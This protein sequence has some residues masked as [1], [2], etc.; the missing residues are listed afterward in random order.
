MKKT[1]CLFAALIMCLTICLPAFAVIAENEAEGIRV[2]VSKK[3]G[4]PVY[5]YSDKTDGKGNFS[6]AYIPTKKKIPENTKFTAD[7][8]TA[9]VTAE[10]GSRFIES[11][12]DGDWIYLALADVSLDLKPVT[13]PGDRAGR[14]RHLTVFDDDVKLYEGP[15]E[16]YRAVKSLPEG[17]EIEAVKY[18]FGGLSCWYYTTV[19]N[20]SGWIKFMNNPEDVDFVCDISY[21]EDI[22]SPTGKIVTLSSLRIYDE[23]DSVFDGEPLASVPAG[24][25]LTFSNY[26]LWEFEDGTSLFAL[27]DYKGTKGWAV[28]VDEDSDSDAMYQVEG[29]MMINEPD[30]VYEDKDLRPGDNAELTIEPHTIVSFD[31]RYNE[32]V[33]TDGEDWFRPYISWYR[34][35]IGGRHY[36]ISFGSDGLTHPAEYEAK[37]YRVSEDASLTLYN[38]ASKKSGKAGAIPAGGSFTLLF[39]DDQNDYAV[40]FYDSNKVWRYVEYDGSR[41]WTQFEWEDAEIIPASLPEITLS[42][43]ADMPPVTAEDEKEFSLNP[44]KDGKF[45]LPFNLFG[46]KDLGEELD[47]IGDAIDEAVDK[48]EKDPDSIK[49]TAAAARALA[50]KRARREVVKDLIIAGIAAAGI[51]LIKK[52]DEEAA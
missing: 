12:Y 31:Y 43:S 8:E 51:F 39:T 11:E 3:G 6:V 46:D 28:I 22:P 50:K 24:S 25:E 20:V 7:W 47:K 26:V 52:K 45:T 4:A 37:V 19:G 27:V 33:D 42:E 14:V 38:E 44:F 5:E 16:L 17:T 15:S 49:N 41:Y 32:P 48:A 30:S 13:P 18:D 1:V 35:G 29:Y 9:F 36:W 2:T 21:K 23:P 40:S 10:D 34:I